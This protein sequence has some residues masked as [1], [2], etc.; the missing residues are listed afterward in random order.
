MNTEEAAR[1]LGVPAHHVT[2]LDVH[3]AGH[4]ATVRGVLMLVSD[5]VARVYVP[6]V[7]DVQADVEPEPVEDKPAPA[8]AKPA[9]KRGAASGRSA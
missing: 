6:E 4:I 3:P 9:A 2:A 8:K 7:D 1:R 5:T